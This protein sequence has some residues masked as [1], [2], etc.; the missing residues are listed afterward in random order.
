MRHRSRDSFRN[1]FKELKILP[2]ISQHI[3]SLLLF[4]NNKIALS[5]IQKIAVYRPERVTIFIYPRL[6]WLLIKK[7]FIIQ[8]LKFLVTFHKILKTFLTIL[9]DLKDC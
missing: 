9:K 4:I 6:T 5:Q 1:L 2:F 7:V 3:F 8:V